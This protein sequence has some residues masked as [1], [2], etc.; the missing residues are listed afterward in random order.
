MKLT[1]IAQQALKQQNESLNEGTDIGSWNQAG[2]KGNTNALVTTFVGPKEVE[3]FGLGRKCMQINIGLNY[4][5][6]NPADIMELKE[7]LKDYKNES[8]VTEAKDTIGL[9]FKEQ[10][11]YLDFKEFV[12]E[13]PRGAIRKDIGF[14]SKTKSWYVEM[15]V[16]VLD[17][18]YGEGTPGNKESGWYGGLPGDFESVIISESIV[19][20]AT[21]NQVN[22]SSE[23]YQ[24]MKK[25]KAFK[26]HEWKWNS[27]T[28]LWT[29]K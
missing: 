18:I 16:K 26:Q 1:T 12:A 27:D 28:Q 19:N 22:L 24:K 11:D 10:Q 9:A 14:D 17:S 15:D 6:L 2:V 25:L 23:E 4:V 8:V 7:L 21:I 3:S 29:K 20:E 5:Q 13:Q